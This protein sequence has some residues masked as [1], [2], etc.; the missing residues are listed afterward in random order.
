MGGFFTVVQ[1]LPDQTFNLTIRDLSGLFCHVVPLCKRNF[2][3]QYYIKKIMFPFFK[4]LA[5]QDCFLHNTCC[6]GFLYPQR[7]LWQR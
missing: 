4:V 7:K 1:C 6:A 3:L 2:A 5:C